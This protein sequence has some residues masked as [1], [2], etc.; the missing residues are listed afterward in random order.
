MK[1]IILV[2][3]IAFVAYGSINAMGGMKFVGPDVDKTRELLIAAGETDP[4]K[5]T[6]YYKRGYTFI[7]AD[8]FKGTRNETGLKKYEQLP[9]SSI[10]KAELAAN[11]KIHLMPA[12]RASTVTFLK[13]FFKELAKNKLFQK[14]I[15]EIKIISFRD[16]DLDD[17]PKIIDFFKKKKR[18]LPIIVIYPASGKESAQYAL[19]MIYKLFKRMSGLGVEPTFNEKITNAIFVAQGDSD[20]KLDHPKFYS[21]PNKIYFKKDFEGLNKNYKILNPATGQVTYQNEVENTDKTLLFKKNKKASYEQP[22]RI[23]KINLAQIKTALSPQKLLE[24]LINND[25]KILRLGFKKAGAPS[26]SAYI[27]KNHPNIAAIEKQKV[28]K[29]AKK[30]YSYSKRNFE[31]DQL[32]GAFKEK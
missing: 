25:L 30:L 27:N 26:Y 28:S 23:E 18:I 16:L 5:F 22:N 24:K 11:Y 1:K 10:K 7:E 14:T 4:K 8:E 12:D 32:M 29:A 9:I 13:D 6:V 17:K 31:Y 20:S 19:N 15:S 2:L 21:E 3:S